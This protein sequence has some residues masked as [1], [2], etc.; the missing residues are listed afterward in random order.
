LARNSSFIFLSVGFE[1]WQKINVL[2][3]ALAFSAQTL[4]IAGFF[5][6]YR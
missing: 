1:H 4:M 2:D 3:Q 6:H 5:L